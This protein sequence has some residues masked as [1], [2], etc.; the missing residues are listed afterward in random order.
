VS[1]FH[2]SDEAFLASLEE[3]TRDDP[4]ALLSRWWAELRVDPAVA[5][6]AALVPQDRPLTLFDALPLAAAA[7]AQL[8]TPELQLAVLDSAARAYFRAA[9]LH[10]TEE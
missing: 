4:E 9:G 7:V 3:R 2:A 5:S 6:L 8:Q 1:T 10:I